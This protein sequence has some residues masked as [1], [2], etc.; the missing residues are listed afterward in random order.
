MQTANEQADFS[1]A[2]PSDAA[3]LPA[4][5]AL[6]S[7]R[8]SR[9]CDWGAELTGAGF[10]VGPS[11][12]ISS[13]LEGEIVTLGDAIVLDC[14]CADAETLAALA[15]LDM[16]VARSG[17]PLIV[18]TSMAALDDVFG[19]FAESAPQIL[20]DPGSAQL[21]VAMGRIL[22]LVAGRKVRELSEKE[23]MALLHLSEQVDAIAR[24]LDEFTD[25]GGAQTVAN[26]ADE[27]DVAA[28]SGGGGAS[29]MPKPSF[30]K[31]DTV[32]RAIRQRQARARF[33][34]PE[35]FADPAWDMLLDLTAAH[36][37]GQQVCVTSLCI[38]SGVPPTTAL[39]WI[40]QMVEQ[41]VF[42]RV[43]DEADRRRAFIA[44]SEK[45]RECMAR[46]FAA[47]EEPLALAA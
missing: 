23:R 42:I 27:S 45:S 1:Y 13:L 21:V 39:R 37:E 4:R 22:G 14:P 12:P 41:G 35:L 43:E 3:G 44:L 30:P 47:L 16:R 33:F 38:A 31:P 6:F 46:Y 24:R 36:G 17:T 29:L 28:I 34:D 26:L 32:R 40:G 8:G 7:D 20:I 11:A 5:I 18:L 19:C 2:A 15:R 10:A 9:R 25:H